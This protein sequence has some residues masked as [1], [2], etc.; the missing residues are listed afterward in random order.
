MRFRDAEGSADVSS[1]QDEKISSSRFL[2]QIE[3]NQTLTAL[4]LLVEASRWQHSKQED[5]F[6][7]EAFGMHD[8]VQALDIE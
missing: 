3:V 1:S 7:R 6:M 8:L 5:A 2:K 4:Y